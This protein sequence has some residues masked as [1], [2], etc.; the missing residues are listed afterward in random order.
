M[1]YF[2]IFFETCDEASLLFSK[3]NLLSATTFR[4][5]SSEKKTINYK[6]KCSKKGENWAIPTIKIPNLEWH[7]SIVELIYVFL[8]STICF[9]TAI[10]LWQIWSHNLLF[11]ILKKTLTFLLISLSL[12]F[13]GL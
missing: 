13:F 2:I 1:H 11:F 6:K 4:A 9:T 3:F 7:F 12:H 5:F 10:K 8:Y